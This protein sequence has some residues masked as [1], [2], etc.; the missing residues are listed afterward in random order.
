MLLLLAVCAVLAVV[1]DGGGAAARGALLGDGIDAFLSSKYGS[2]LVGDQSG[3]QSFAAFVARSQGRRRAD[4]AR[5]AQSQGRMAGMFARE[6]GLTARRSAA[7]SST[8]AAGAAGTVAS[9]KQ[10]EALDAAANAF[11]VS[12]RQPCAGKPCFAV[13]DDPRFRGVHSGK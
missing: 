12:A 5:A 6:L 10:E 4:H 13:I 9:L 2:G 7:T 11:S 3:D 1:R 8:G